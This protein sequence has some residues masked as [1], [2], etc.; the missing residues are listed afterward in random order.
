MSGEEHSSAFSNVLSHYDEC[1]VSVLHVLR[2]VD[3]LLKS[4]KED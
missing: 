1:F 3:T 2:E 4:S